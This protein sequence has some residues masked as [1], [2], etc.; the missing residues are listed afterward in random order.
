MLFQKL[1]PYEGSC[2]FE[3]SAKKPKKKMKKVKLKKR[4]K[5]FTCK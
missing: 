2:E 3:F 5:M 1:I 4:N